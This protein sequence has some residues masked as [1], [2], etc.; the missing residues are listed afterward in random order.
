MYTECIPED[1][2]LYILDSESFSIPTKSI[3]ITINNWYDNPQKYSNNTL[4]T[5]ES[6][7]TVKPPHKEN[8]N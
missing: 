4:Y 2:Y 1:T 5:S 8:N 3:S 7:N 6:D